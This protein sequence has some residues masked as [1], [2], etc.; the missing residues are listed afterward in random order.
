[1][2][3][4]LHAFLVG[5]LVF[6]VSMDAARACWFLRRGC[7]TAMPVWSACPPPAPWW[8][9]PAAPAICCD[10]VVVGEAASGESWDAVSAPVVIDDGVFSTDAGMA[11]E[12]VVVHDESSLVGETIE[13][14]EPHGD[15][16]AADTVPPLEEVVALPATEPQ[17]VVPEPAPTSV[18]VP[19]LKPAADASRDVQPTSAT[20]DEAMQLGTV[21][22]AAAAA[23]PAGEAP[24]AEAAVPASPSEPNLFEEADR[25]AELDVAPADA[26]SEAPPATG[27][28]APP[29]APPA[30]D[31]VEDAPA[32]PAAEATNPLDAAERRS[33]E[34]ARL[35]VDATGRHSTVGVLVAVRAD[36]RCV[37]DTGTGILEVP[38]AALRRR[39]R[40]YAAQASERLA[41]RRGPGPVETAGR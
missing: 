21:P 35:W 5:V 11:F 38:P 17:D 41:G 13:T 9:D 24:V 37:I 31:P 12:A 16:T 23:E 40:E 36:G 26:A 4:C 10:V 25:A 34:R 20:Q 1:M 2:R 8:H 18:V 15:V 33:G 14:I 39:D 22:D 29:P 19:D 28:D 3:R 27:A 6:A 7:G 30:T 32:E